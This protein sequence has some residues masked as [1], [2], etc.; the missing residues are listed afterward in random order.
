MRDVSGMGE[1]GRER[2]R[3]GWGG[4]G[5]GGGLGGRSRRLRKSTPALDFSAKPACA[6]EVPCVPWPMPPQ[7]CFR[8]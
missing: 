1:G 3:R 5:G 6:Q 7:F 2:G 8:L 4:R